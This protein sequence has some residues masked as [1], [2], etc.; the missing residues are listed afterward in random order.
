MWTFPF[1]SI[2]KI[3]LIISRYVIDEQVFYGKFSY[4]QVYLFFACIPNFTYF[5][6]DPEAHLLAR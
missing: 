6:Y 1:C 2:H 3:A 4:D 5:F